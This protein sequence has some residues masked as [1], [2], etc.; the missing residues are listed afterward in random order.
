[1][2]NFPD[3]LAPGRVDIIIFPNGGKEVIGRQPSYPLLPET[4]YL[5]KIR[6]FVATKQGLEKPEKFTGFYSSKENSV[7]MTWTAWAGEIPQEE[8]VEEG[9]TE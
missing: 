4:A 9:P 1:M 5:N 2:S 8:P 7:S 6:D 3:T